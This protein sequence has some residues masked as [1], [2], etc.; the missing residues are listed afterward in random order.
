MSVY[1]NSIESFVDVIE[2][3]LIS[4]KD[5]AELEQL[6]SQLPEEDEEISKAIENW[7]QPK[8][9]SQIRQAYEERLE[10]LIN[11]SDI[12]IDKNL[13]L[14]GSRSR[15]PPNQPSLV[16]KVLLLNAI[17]RRRRESASSSTPSD[18]P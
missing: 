17:R 8:S 13:G 11:P 12:D 7:L 16:S 1:R 4:S 5:L 10:A 18:K 6:V 3:D 15:T 9:R 14:A 2:S